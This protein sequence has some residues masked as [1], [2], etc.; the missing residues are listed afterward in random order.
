M[1]KVSLENVVKGAKIVPDNILLTGVPKIGKTTFAASFPDHFFLD[2]DGGASQ[3]GG[4]RT[5][6][7]IT[8]LAMFEEWIQALG[9]EDHGYKNVI[10]DTVDGLERLIKEDLCRKHG[11]ESMENFQ[12]GQG[13]GMLVNKF[14]EIFKN[15]TYLKNY[16]DINIIW[17]CHSTI[18]K[19][20]DVDG[21][22]YDK[23]IP[24]V[25]YKDE[26]AETCSSIL[27]NGCDIL[28]HARFK[29]LTKK[30]GDSMVKKSVAISSQR[31][32]SHDSSKLSEISGSRYNLPSE[33]PLDYAVFA[34]ELA[35]AKNQTI[36]KEEN[37]E[38]KK[39]KGE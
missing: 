4:T 16:K 25:Y 23:I 39:E 19:I 35:K 38:N 15:L 33:M 22:E 34:E 31:I 5:P 14:G 28:L 21:N 27:V 6:E 1:S 10:I 24:N 9:M 3:V 29:T 7:T 26:K 37:Q 18:K 20:V 17:L 8:T 30:V 11:K 13:Y 32:I 36:N 2:I 12:W